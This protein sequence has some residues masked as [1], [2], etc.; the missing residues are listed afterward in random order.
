MSKQAVNLTSGGHSQATI[1]Q[2]AAQ[3]SEKDEGK[4]SEIECSRLESNQV[5]RKRRSL[6]QVPNLVLA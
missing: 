2:S 3:F 1:I 5:I 6:S 4:V